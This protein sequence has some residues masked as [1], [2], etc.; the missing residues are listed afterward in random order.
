[1]AKYVIKTKDGSGW[2]QGFMPKIRNKNKKIILITTSIDEAKYFQTRKEAKKEL[3]FNKF[4][5]SNYIIDFVESSG[6]KNLEFLGCKEYG[7]E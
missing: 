3:R 5:T 1:M 7:E 6:P 4:A 2:I